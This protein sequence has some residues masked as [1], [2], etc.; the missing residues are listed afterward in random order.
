MRTIGSRENHHPDKS[1]W[2]SQQPPFYCPM[3]PLDRYDRSWTS[4]WINFPEDLVPGLQ[5]QFEGESAAL[6]LRHDGREGNAF[7]G[8]LG[9]YD[10][11]GESFPV[12]DGL[13]DSEVGHGTHSATNIGGPFNIN[14]P[15]VQPGFHVSLS[16]QE[17]IPV[18]QFEFIDTA[19]DK[20][21]QVI[22]TRNGDIFPPDFSNYLTNAG[23][24]ITRSNKRVSPFP[25]EY[26]QQRQKDISCNEF[27]LQT[28]E[29]SRFQP[30]DDDQ[31][32]PS[33]VP[34]PDLQSSSTANIF[35]LQPTT[36][37]DAA[38]LPNPKPLFHYKQPK[39]TSSL[40]ASH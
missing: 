12:G 37:P 14:L 35:T 31:I 26:R 33:S 5:A 2:W 39:K 28:T 16:Q 36:V 27:Q 7:S 17:P 30:L 25:F 34:N 15:L 29:D 24:S 19:E 40:P 32:S 6:V 11:R 20:G 9:R 4:E 1:E 18:Q 13:C 22:Q 3:A 38:E 21:Y 8:E 10:R 23:D